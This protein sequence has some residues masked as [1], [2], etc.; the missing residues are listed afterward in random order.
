MTTASVTASVTQFQPSASPAIVHARLFADRFESVRQ[1]VTPFTAEASSTYSQSVTPSS[2]L[3]LT[4]L[5]RRSVLPTLMEVEAETAS[6]AFC[7]LDSSTE[8]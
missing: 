5:I 8:A 3:D 6:V 2:L 4:L 1:S 7:S